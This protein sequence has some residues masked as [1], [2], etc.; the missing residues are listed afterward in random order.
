MKARA[1]LFTNVDQMSIE[2]IKLPRIEP[3]EVLIGLWYTCIGHVIRSEGAIVP[4]P[5]RV[6]PFDASIASPAAIAFHGLRLS[7]PLPPEADDVQV[8]EPV[9]HLYA[10]LQQSQSALFTTALD[11]RNKQ[12]KE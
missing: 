6:N 11:W 3:Q 2:P 12:V 5:Q 4:I 9:H 8:L 1:L 10:A 7:K